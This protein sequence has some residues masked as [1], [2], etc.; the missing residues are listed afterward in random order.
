MW[1]YAFTLREAVTACPEA[2][3][4]GLRSLTYTTQ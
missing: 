2:L 3:P 1:E 4:N